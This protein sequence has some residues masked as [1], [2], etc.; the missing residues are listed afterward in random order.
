MSKTARCDLSDAQE[1]VLRKFLDD[2]VAEKIEGLGEVTGMLLHRMGYKM[3]AKG[4]LIRRDTDVKYP[5]GDTDPFGAYEDEYTPDG[6]AL[7]ER[8]DEASNDSD[9]D[10]TS[11]SESP[12]GDEVGNLL[13]Q[14]V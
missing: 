1:H 4:K 3:I 6:E 10:E 9:T 8:M 14:D 12:E 5:Y 13:Q 2:C 11:T 7:Q